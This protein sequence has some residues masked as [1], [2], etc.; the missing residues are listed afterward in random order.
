MLGV[1][2]EGRV[3]RYWSLLLAVGVCCLMVNCAH[4]RDN[5]LDSGVGVLTQT[6]VKEKLGKPHIVN[7]PLLSDETTWMYRHVLTEG[8]LDPWGIETFG[9]EAG[10]LLGGAEGLSREKIY[11]YVYTLTFDKEAVLRH[12]KRDLCQVPTPPN[13]FEQRLSGKLRLPQI[14]NEYLDIPA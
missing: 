2:F 13:I 14:V 9:K 7:D 10:S 3:V 12:W 8:E 4:W 5:Y 11:C 1:N 6:D